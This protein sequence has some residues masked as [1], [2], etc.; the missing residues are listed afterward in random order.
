M[1][2]QGFRFGFRNTTPK[3]DIEPGA[4][5]SLS[6]LVT[7]STCRAGCKTLRILKVKLTPD[8]RAE[9]MGSIYCL[10]YSSR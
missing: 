8:V 1:V 10:K 6:D 5:S 7:D 4:F 3:L 2:L 9:V